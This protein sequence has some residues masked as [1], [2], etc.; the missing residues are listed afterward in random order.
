M[1]RNDLDGTLSS[2]FNPSLQQAERMVA[3]VE[4]WILGVK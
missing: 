3:Q 1:H 2:F 4:G